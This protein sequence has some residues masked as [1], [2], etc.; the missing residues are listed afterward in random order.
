MAAK[1]APFTLRLSSSLN[2]FVSEEA[3]R[4]R[5]S[6]GAIVEELAEE[7]A[8]TRL[9]PGIAFKDSGW[10]RRPW[11]MGTGLDVW[12]VI[13]GYQDFGSAERMLQETDLS[14]QQLRVALAYYRR[15]PEE[16]DVA[17]AEN[18]RTID[19]LRELYPTFDVI[20]VD[21]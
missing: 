8:R 17:I 1:S 12:Q 14:E 3:R 6:K 21:V 9:F 4:T 20:L 15:Y 7:A 16:I 13:E 10:D 18:R 11:V 2:A 5:R 19:E